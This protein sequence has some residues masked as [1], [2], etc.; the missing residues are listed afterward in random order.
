MENIIFCAEF[1][2]SVSYLMIHLAIKSI[3]ETKPQFQTWL[4][5]I[6]SYTT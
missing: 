2:F 6:F 1:S 3:L 5:T 4:K